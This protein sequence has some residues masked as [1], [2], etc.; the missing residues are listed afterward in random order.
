MT[1]TCDYTYL[2]VGGVGQTPEH[3][4]EFTIAWT[5]TQRG[6]ETRT[7]EEYVIN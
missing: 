1:F 6:A 3:Q 2:S 4:I 5:S 7:Y